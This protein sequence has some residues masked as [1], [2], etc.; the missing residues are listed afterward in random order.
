M[1]YKVC[2]TKSTAHSSIPTHAFSSYHMVLTCM[3]MMVPTFAC[4]HVARS[5]P[6][7]QTAVFWHFSNLHVCMTIHGRMEMEKKKKR[8]MMSFHLSKSIY[9]AG[10][11]GVLDH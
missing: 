3:Q 10:I 8:L 5:S 11:P 9:G 4:K 1:Q 6:L 7:L 2:R